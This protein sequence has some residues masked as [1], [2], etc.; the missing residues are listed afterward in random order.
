[1]KFI[2][3]VDRQAD[4]SWLA[5][6]PTVPDCLSTGTTKEEALAN[7]E[8]VIRDIVRVRS[9]PEM[10]LTIEVKE[11]QEDDWSPPKA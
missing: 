2:V 6:C 11:T 1:M 5:Q 10:P 8:D 3:S 4:G 9:G 7:V